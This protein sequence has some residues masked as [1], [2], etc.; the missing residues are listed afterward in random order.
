MTTS[1]IGR[2]YIITHIR[3]TPRKY[4]IHIAEPSHKTN[5]IQFVLTLR[6]Q[7]GLTRPQ[8]DAIFAE[9]RADY[10]DAKFVKVDETTHTVEEI[11]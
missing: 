6:Y 9:L 8:A 1:T 4:V 11:S 10:P 2:D 3:K 7:T 5:G